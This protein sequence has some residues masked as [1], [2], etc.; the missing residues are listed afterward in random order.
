[1]H[2][3]A[4]ALVEAEQGC[5]RIAPDLSESLLDRLD[6]GAEPVRARQ[7]HVADDV[8]DGGAV[9][10]RRLRRARRCLAA[11]LEEQLQGEEIA[12]DAPGDRCR[13]GHAEGGERR[14]RLP[15]RRERTGQFGIDQTLDPLPHLRGRGAHLLGAQNQTDH[16]RSPLARPQPRGRPAPAP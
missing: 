11:E 12:L 15:L 1:M 16:D 3:D 5:L 10:V 2:V 7:A 8:G 14:R 6:G 9:Q 13:F 4:A